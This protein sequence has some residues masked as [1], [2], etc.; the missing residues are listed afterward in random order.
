M[1]WGRR[2]IAA[3]SGDDLLRWGVSVL[4]CEAGA[5]IRLGPL[6]GTV[7]CTGR[8]FS[9]QGDGGFSCGFGTSRV[10]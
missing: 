9:G 3:V 5:R 4:V 8:L 2:P 6:S 10:F 1:G 7:S